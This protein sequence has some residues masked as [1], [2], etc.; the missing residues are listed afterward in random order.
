MRRARLAGPPSS[1]RLRPRRH[2]RASRPVSRYRTTQPT[3]RTRH[4]RLQRNTHTHT[5]TLPPLAHSEP[6]KTADWLPRAE[7]GLPQGAQ[8]SAI[9]SRGS[10][11]CVRN[12]GPGSH[13]AFSFFPNIYKRFLIILQRILQRAAAQAAA[14]P[15]SKRGRSDGSIGGTKSSP[16]IKKSQDCDPYLTITVMGLKQTKRIKELKHT[17]DPDWDETINFRS[18]RCVPP[19]ASLVS[20]VRACARARGGVPWL[21]VAAAE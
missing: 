10:S 5:H 7:D 3:R 19:G 16:A 1:R 20:S 9:A 4:A 17:R 12:T 6:T 14:T 2:P 21:T 15:N 11:L 8:H 13:C 18:V